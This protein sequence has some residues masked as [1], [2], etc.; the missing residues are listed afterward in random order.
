VRSAITIVVFLT[1]CAQIESRLVRQ[2]VVRTASP[3]ADSTTVERVV[4]EPLEAAIANAPGVQFIKSQ[5]RSE[6]SLI[7]VEF[8]ANSPHAEIESKV[9][10]LVQQAR[11]TLSVTSEPST[12]E[13]REG[14][15]LRPR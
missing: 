13:T 14:P 9:R 6:L 11:S 3:G 15:S 7:T 12:F 5:S 1:A 8:D 10:T 2:V 4:T